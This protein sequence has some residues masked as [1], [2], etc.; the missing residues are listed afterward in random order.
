MGLIE[1]WIAPT[2]TG[3]ILLF[4]SILYEKFMKSKENKNA[5]STAEV[6]LLDDMRDL[7]IELEENS[8]GRGSVDYPFHYFWLQEVAKNPLYRKKYPLALE[9]A[10]KC[11]GLA[12]SKQGVRPAEVQGHINELKEEIIKIV[13]PPKVLDSAVRD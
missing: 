8:K 1:N 5:E 13:T 3:F 6:V 4:G 7:I 2:I 12:S 11:L 10:L 9:K